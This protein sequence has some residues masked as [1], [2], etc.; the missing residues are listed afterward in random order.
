MTQF[1]R[2]EGPVRIVCFP[3]GGAALAVEDSWWCGSTKY[4]GW[5]EGEGRDRDARW[6]ATVRDAVRFAQ[7]QGWISE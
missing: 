6:F 3:S 7:A 2:P 5:H 1:D 4:T